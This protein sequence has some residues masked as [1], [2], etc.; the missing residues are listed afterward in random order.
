MR[1][2]TF[3]FLFLWALL[4]AYFHFPFDTFCIQLYLNL[5]FYLVQSHQPSIASNDHSFGHYDML[6]PTT[7]C[8]FTACEKP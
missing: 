4:F 1:K 3:D 2:F 5:V 6:C 8:A 7:S